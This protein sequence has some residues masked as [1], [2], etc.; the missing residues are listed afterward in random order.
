M[1]V[2]FGATVGCQSERRDLSAGQPPAG[3]RPDG[4]IPVAVSVVPQAWLVGEIGG[5]HVDVMTLVKPGDSPEVYQPTDV[6]VSRVMTAKAFFCIGMPFEKGRAFQAIESSGKVRMIDT[7]QGI[8]LRRALP[9]AHAEDDGHAH[10]QNKGHASAEAHQESVGAHAGYDP[11]IWSSPRLLAIQARTVAQALRELDP[12]HAA[13]YD[14][15]LAAVEQRI[16][17]TDQ[18]IRKILAPLRG[19]AFFVFHPAWGYFA[20]DYGLHQV[21]IESEGKD[22]SDR[23][24][25]QL[26]QLARREGIKVIFVQPQTASRAA[27]AVARAIGGRVE[28]LD[29][30]ASDVLGN[31]VRVAQAIA[32]DR[33]EGIGE[34]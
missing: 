2:L 26:Q 23:E 20:D 12:T 18:K 15:N 13:D 30:L 5:D 11:H 21:A 22:P 32:G 8:T 9:H 10:E 16:E 17:H 19:K 4:K 25:T 34:R 1:A 33:G 27:E 14:R 7:R 28:A 29:P 3:E 31:L 6:Q 24:L